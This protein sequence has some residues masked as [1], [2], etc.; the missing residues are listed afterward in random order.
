MARAEAS[1]LILIGWREWLALPDLGIA[2]IKTK[3][4]TGARSS[5]LHVEELS[6]FMFRGERWVRFRLAPGSRRSGRQQVVES[7]ITDERLVTDSGG[8]RALRPF[9]RTRV[10][11]GPWSWPV[12]INLTDRRAMLF[13]MLLGRSAITGRAMVHPGISFSLG[14]PSIASSPCSPRASVKD[15]RVVAQSLKSRRGD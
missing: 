5:A 3:I 15:S 11:L 6:E 9:I 13:P 10:A 1:G 2:A 12:E 7:P 8:N 4:D 14:R